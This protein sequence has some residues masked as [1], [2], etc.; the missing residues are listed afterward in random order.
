MRYNK[1][2][3]KKEVHSNIDPAQETRKVSNT[4]SNLTHKEMR[5]RANKAKISKRKEITMMRM[6]ISKEKLKGQ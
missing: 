6:D 5:K 1:N 4:Q 2:N 3:I